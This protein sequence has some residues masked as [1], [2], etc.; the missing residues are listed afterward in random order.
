MEYG[1]ATE[2]LADHHGSTGTYDDSKVHYD[3]E[4]GYDSHVVEHEEGCPCGASCLQ[5]LVEDEDEYWSDDDTDA[6]EDDHQAT[7]EMSAPE[8]QQ[9]L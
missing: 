6:D 7:L 3:C 8:L 2:R 1:I 5:Y 9:S 4:D